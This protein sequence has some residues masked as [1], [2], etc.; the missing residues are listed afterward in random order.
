[1]KQRS[2]LLFIIL[3]FQFGG[4]IAAGVNLSWTPPTQRENNDSYNYA[5]ETASVSIFCSASLNGTYTHEVTLTGADITPPYNLTTVTWGYC[6]INITDI[7]G[8]QSA[9][10]SIA[11]RIAPLTGFHKG[12]K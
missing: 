1:M 6:Y 7:Y 3:C 5:T 11:N 4:A 2:I 12:W 9:D 10:S 8:N